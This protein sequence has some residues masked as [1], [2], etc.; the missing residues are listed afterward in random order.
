MRLPR[1]ARRLVGALT[2]VGVLGCADTIDDA[3]TSFD[4]ACLEGCTEN[5]SGSSWCDEMCRC[6]YAF[7]ADETSEVELALL[8][9]RAVVP[10]V[11]TDAD[12]QLL[13]AAAERCVA[14]A[15]A[16]VASS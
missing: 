1:H 15:D 6:A 9:M 14:R 12:R 2:F 3:R 11:Q 4:E 10:A 13:E 16:T 8:F 7:L 5:G